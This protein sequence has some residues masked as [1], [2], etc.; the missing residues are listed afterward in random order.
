MAMT[1]LAPQLRLANEA[2][3]R[4]ALALAAA[5]GA[6]QSDAHRRNTLLYEALLAWEES[7]PEPS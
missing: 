1:P 3:R 7:R 6:E 4:D 2:R 5:A